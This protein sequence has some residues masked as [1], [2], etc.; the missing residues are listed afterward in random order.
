PFVLFY[1]PEN[2]AINHLLPVPYQNFYYSV[3]DYRMHHK[4]QE[5][6]IAVHN[7]DNANDDEIYDKLRK[8]HNSYIAA[9]SHKH[10][11]LWTAHI[12]SC[13]ERELLVYYQKV[14]S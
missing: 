11:K 13:F 4:H 5:Q 2:A 12:P 3:S 10:C 8:H 6:D 7:N 14:I 1:F 9:S